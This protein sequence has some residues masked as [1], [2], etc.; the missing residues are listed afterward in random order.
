[1]PEKYFYKGFEIRT[2]NSG[3]GVEVI[4]P[5]LGNKVI[6]R[7]DRITTAKLRIE[8]IESKADMRRAEKELNEILK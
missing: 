2:S 4:A 6:M 3:K 5:Q 8:A 7:A 1:M